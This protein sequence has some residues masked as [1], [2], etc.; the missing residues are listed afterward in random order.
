MNEN[1]YL[2][3]SI[4]RVQINR[5]YVTQPQTKPKHTHINT[6]KHRFIMKMLRLG[7]ATNQSLRF[8]PN[9]NKQRKMESK[10]NFKR[11]RESFGINGDEQF[12]AFMMAAFTKTIECARAEKTRKDNYNYF[13]MHNAFTFCA[14]VGN[15]FLAKR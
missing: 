3:S 4:F 13:L 12:Q 8:E 14:C 11:G 6:N 7:P 2:I 10:K 5:K 9:A 15:K 1:K